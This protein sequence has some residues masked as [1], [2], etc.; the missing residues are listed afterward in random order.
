MVLEKLLCLLQVVWHGA[1]EVVV[2][3]TGCLA[4]CWRSYCVCYRLFGMVLEELL[5]LLQVAWH[6]P[7]EVVVS[8]TGCLALC[9]RSCCICCRLFG[10]VLEKL[11]CLLQVARHELS[12]IASQFA[13]QNLRFAM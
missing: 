2:S 4:W 10:M 12:G 7:G 9:W 11:L 5:C 13:M 1:G 8:A 6:G 3:A